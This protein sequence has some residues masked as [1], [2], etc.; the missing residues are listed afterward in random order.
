MAMLEELATGTR[1]SGLGR[2]GGMT[3]ESVLRVVPG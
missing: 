3:I 1:V 2:A